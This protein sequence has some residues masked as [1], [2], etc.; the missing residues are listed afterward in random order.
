MIAASQVVSKAIIPAQELE[1][2]TSNLQDFELDVEAAE[3]TLQEVHSQQETAT[4]EPEKE[5]PIRDN[6]PKGL[7]SCLR[8]E[9]VIVRNINKKTGFKINDPKHVLYGGMAEGAIKTFTVPQLQS[10]NFVNVLTD[11]EKEFLYTLNTV[12]LPGVSEEDEVHINRKTWE[13]F[14]YPNG[15]EYLKW[16]FFNAGSGGKK[17][18]FN[19]CYL[20][21]M[22][23]VA[24]RH[25]L[26]LPSFIIIDSPMKNIDKEVNEDL[27]KRFYD[28]LYNLAGG[29]L[30]MTQFI[31]IDNSYVSPKNE[32]LQFKDRYM[33][34]N[35][36]QH[37]PLISYYRGA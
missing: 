2:E 24:A 28:H 10:G 12:G 3:P 16:N 4:E 27:F 9:T 15:E 14:V 33:T 18:L 31:I 26:L 1:N 5:T 36:D 7:V 29:V 13:L 20:L 8:N 21:S 11:L 37:P 17:T 19:V 34:D 22:H 32:K 6:N 23:V 25:N 30:N 35:D